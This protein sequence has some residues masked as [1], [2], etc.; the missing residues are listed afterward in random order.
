[1]AIT[2]N[3]T[4]G[5]TTPD[6]TNSGALGVNAS[7]P[8][9]SLVVGS[10]GNVGI[11]TSSPN[12]TLEVNGGTYNVPIAA[13]STDAYSYITM[14]D[15]T[16]TGAVGNASVAVGALGDAMI[17][18]TNQAERARID[19]AGRV[20]MPYQPSFDAYTPAVTSEDNTVIFGSTRHNEGSHYSTS[21][22]LFTAPI[23]GVYFFRFSL[24]MGNPYTASYHRILWI[25]NNVASVSYGDT[26]TD[27]GGQ[28]SYHATQGTLVIKL[29]AND[30]VGV[31]NAGPIPT[32]GTSYGSWGGFLIG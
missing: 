6:I 30:T 20:T 21:T 14:M 24:L 5:I 10:T 28:T 32:Y 15:N 2:L 1:M 7:A 27:K 4:T 25:V 17:F 9:N 29:S 31:Y 18:R 12:A 11:G 19:S 23:N 8:D 26:L 22:G 3:G 13:I 16:T